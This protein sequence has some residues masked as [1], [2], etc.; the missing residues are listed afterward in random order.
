MPEVVV[1]VS[2]KTL[3][4]V[5]LSVVLVLV[6]TPVLVASVLMEPTVE[7][8]VDSLDELL[9]AAEVTAKTAHTAIAADA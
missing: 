4:V 6:L 1:D 3:D 2:T 8:P 7:L 9:H 5:V